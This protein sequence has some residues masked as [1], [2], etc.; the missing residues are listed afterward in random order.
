VFVVCGIIK[1]AKTRAGCRHKLYKLAE[2][3]HAKTRLGVPDDGIS[4]QGVSAHIQFK[5]VFKE[6]FQAENFYSSVKKISQEYN[7]RKPFNECMNSN[8]VPDICVEVL[9]IQC[10]VW[11]ADLVLIEEDQY[12][13]IAGDV[14]PSPDYDP[15]TST[16]ASA[17]SIDDETR[18][19]LLEREDSV[20]LF[21]QKA[22]QC[23][24]VS[25][26]SDKANAGNPNNI[27]YMSRLLH[28]HF[29]AIDST[30]GIPTFYLRYVCHSSQSVRG[31]VKKKP[32][33]VY[34]TKLQVVFK[35]EEAKNLLC[36]F[37]IRP[38]AVDQTTIEISAF[39]PDPLQFKSFANANAESTL[40]KWRSY[41]GLIND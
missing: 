20:Q 33:A 22:E 8:I 31:V 15:M 14:D 34:E 40:A 23:H 30:E 13:K 35:D 37:F 25:R 18:L 39:F 1:F 10:E 32:S 11:E 17:V 5:M 16:Q 41:D 36:R 19:R 2:E 4:Y 21:R 28:Q 6:E 7:L 26:K 9:R 29:D 3:C 38:A 24:I 27:V 12:Q